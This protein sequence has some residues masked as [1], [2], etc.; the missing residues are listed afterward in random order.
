MAVNTSG[1]TT[2]PT[3]AP[4]GM[5]RANKGKAEDARRSNFHTPQ[6]VGVPVNHHKGIGHPD[7]TMKPPVNN[8]EETPNF[9]SIKVI[10][11]FHINTILKLIKLIA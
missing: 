9:S 2:R 11:L 4:V 1:K 8:P 10:F 7:S 3:V 5:I 6:P